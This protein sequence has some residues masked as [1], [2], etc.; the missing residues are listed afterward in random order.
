MHCKEEEEGG[1]GRL[2]EGLGVR[3]HEEDAWGGSRTARTG[4]GKEGEGAAWNDREG[5]GNVGSLFT[6]RG[7]NSF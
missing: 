6:G 7:G 3:Q 5:Q 2:G 1:E 4:E